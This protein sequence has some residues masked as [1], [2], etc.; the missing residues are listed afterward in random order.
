MQKES[1]DYLRGYLAGAM[2]TIKIFE[3]ARIMD[4]EPATEE[5]PL[6]KSE[7]ISAGMKRAWARR[8]AK[9]RVGRPRKKKTV[10]D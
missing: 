10:L 3:A 1:S 9:K 5:T 6:G 4:N 8:R 2:T 7:K